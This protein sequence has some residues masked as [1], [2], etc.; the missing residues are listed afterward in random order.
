MMSYRLLKIFTLSSACIFS[1]ACT[2]ISSPP[3][4]IATPIEISAWETRLPAEQG[5]VKIT[6]SLPQHA[7]AE[8]QLFNGK[9]GHSNYALARVM[10]SDENCTS[11]HLGSINYKKSRSEYLIQYFEKEASWSRTNTITL[12]WNDN[13]QI[14]TKLNGEVINIDMLSNAT[15]LKIVSHLAP[16]EIQSLEYLPL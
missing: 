10:L 4:T 13:S 1:L 5:T 16:V 6:F 11:G 8:F 2:S 7:R 14:T 15:T 9:P 12:S 3:T